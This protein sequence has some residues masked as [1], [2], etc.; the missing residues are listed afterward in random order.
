M[1][2]PRYVWLVCGVRVLVIDT[3]VLTGLIAVLTIRATL[4]RAT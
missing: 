1:T 2:G 4:R 3:L